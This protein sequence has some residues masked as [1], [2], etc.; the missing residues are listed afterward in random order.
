MLTSK[1]RSGL[2]LGSFALL[3]GCGGET[4]QGIGSQCAV[5][6]TSLSDPAV[7]KAM[8]DL[9][10]HHALDGVWLN[11]S[12]AS[13]AEIDVT[14]GDVRPESTPGNPCGGKLLVDAT[15][16][17]KTRDGLVNA[18]G[19]VFTFDHQ[20]APR[21]AVPLPEL[22]EAFAHPDERFGR[23]NQQDY[24]YPQT[25]PAPTTPV[26]Y[27]VDTTNGL[28]ADIVSNGKVVATW[29]SYVLDLPKSAPKPYAVPAELVP[30]CARAADVM[31][32]EHTQFASAADA[33]D[34]TIGTW[35]RCRSYSRAE[36]DG[37]QISPDGTWR[38][39]TWA[40]GAFTARP[41]LG[42]E[43]VLGDPIDTSIMNGPGSYQVNLNGAA[44]FFAGHT[45]EDRL[46]MSDWAAPPEN[47]TAVYVRSD[48]TV[49][50]AANHFDVGQ[51]AGMDAC[52]TAETGTTELAAGGALD[53]TL[54]GDWVVCSGDPLEGYTRARFG[55]NGRI[56][57]LD[58]AG[59]EMA[60]RTF[61]TFQ[62]NGAAYSILS[63]G[64][65]KGQ[66][67][68]WTITFSQRPLKMRA[69]TESG[70]AVTRSLSLSALPR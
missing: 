67:D 11:G 33:R 54:A 45:W 56:T 32:A 37:I 47:Q 8:S 26:L 50:P 52:A 12:A 70:H 29:S 24:L 60:N 28:R 16:T 49:A 51:R 2:V 17:V 19:S 53:A 1:T 21:I 35:V 48:R 5:A 3:L 39:I 7:V 34:A 66:G 44:E 14:F 30:A 57:L 20:G 27:V 61:E 43:G 55:A 23:W 40:N 9:R 15:A 36:H 58:D 42:R 4:P 69:V 13:V 18:S 59:N 41:G 25:T 65:D 46:I 38:L 6:P 63:F 31:G 68:Q 64:E 10:G 22:P 62:P